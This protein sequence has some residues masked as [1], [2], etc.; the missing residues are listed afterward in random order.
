MSSYLEALKLIFSSLKNKFNSPTCRWGVAD[1][2][3]YEDRGPYANGWNLRLPFTN[4]YGLVQSTINWMYAGGGDDQQEQNLSALKHAGDEWFTTLTGRTDA[5][6]KRIIIWG[7]DNPGHCD[8]EKGYPY[9]TLNDT[10]SS[11]TD[12]DRLKVYGISYKIPGPE[13]AWLGLDGKY[14][15]SNCVGGQATAI[16]EATNGQLWDTNFTVAE[17]ENVL[18]KALS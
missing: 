3:D 18:C 1:Y 8:G 13:S 4:D 2:R 17:I 14:R 10:I 16:T 7:G 9:P 11:L 6:V 12:V 5:N 15:F